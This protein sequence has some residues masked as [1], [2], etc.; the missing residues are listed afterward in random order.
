[1]RAVAIALVLVLAGC[2]S[3]TKGAPA[4]ITLSLAPFAIHLR[5]P[6]VDLRSADT[7]TLSSRRFPIGAFRIQTADFK[8]APVSGFRRTGPLSATFSAPVTGEFQIERD[9]AADLSG[10]KFTVRAPEARAIV[11]AFH[12]RDGEDFFGFGEF[13]DGLNARGKIR[14]MQIELD[15]ARDSGLNDV[16]LGV[17]LVL[18]S[19]R[20][21]LL[22]DT[23]HP[24]TF[25]MAAS[26]AGAWAFETV[27]P[28]VSVGV[29][30]RRADQPVAAFLRRYADLAGRANQPPDWAWAPQQWRNVVT[31][32]TEVLAD[33]RAMR[34]HGIPGSVIWID[35]PWETAYNTL[36][37][38]PVQFPNPDGMLRELKAL[39]YETLVWCTE[40]INKSDDSDE[41]TGMA[42]DSGGLYELAVA[43][44]YLVKDGA[45][46]PW[47]FTWWKGTGGIVDFT[48]PKAFDWFSGRVAGLVAQGIAGFKL[49]AGEFVFAGTGLVPTELDQHFAD[50]RPARVMQ[51]DYKRLYHAAFQKALRAERG[52]GGFWVA[53]TG[54]HRT[55]AS[56]MAL[57]PGDLDHGFERATEKNADGKYNVGGL[58]AAV[59]GGLG[60]GLTGFPYFAPDIGGFLNGTPASEALIRWA[61]YAAFTPIMQLGGGGQHNP[62]LP[63]FTAADLALYRKLA[64]VHFKLAPE[65]RKLAR[66]YTATGMPLMRPFYLLWPEDETLRRVEDEYLLG[67]GILVAPVVTPGA[68]RRDVV[69]PPGRWK[70]FFTGAQYGDAAGTVKA[71]VPAPLGTPPV[72]VREGYSPEVLTED[73]DTFVPATAAGVLT[74]SY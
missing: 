71:S 59:V 22:V 19:Q 6:G 40:W 53:R 17:P 45:G 64:K 18:S 8:W 3:S 54:A 42:P 32:A 52:D 33:A 50:G 65:M 66:E 48:N 43:S 37:F 67:E 16:H 1:M 46:D 11:L 61:E 72:F 73:G 39:G 25:D 49:D 36:T 51:A 23:Q 68:T 62:W 69:F 56:A 55:Q 57:W 9:A 60:A 70:H 14:P 27:A 63:P 34:E 31:G 4:E 47:T 13:F 24:V 10:Y 38:N 7:T 28:E 30:V 41:M 12:A 15:L 5:A 58:P 35:S 74:I 26:D 21:A 20:Y 2:G 29:W 44:G